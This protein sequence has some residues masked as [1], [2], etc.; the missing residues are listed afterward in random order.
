MVSEKSSQGSKRSK[1]LR[2][3]KDQVALAFSDNFANDLVK[4]SFRTAGDAREAETTA[5][6]QLADD[7]SKTDDFFNE[8][9]TE[10]HSTVA[11]DDDS[12]VGRL[13][14]RGSTLEDHLE[15]L[16]DDASLTSKGR[17]RQELARRASFLNFGDFFRSQKLDFMMGVVIVLNA[18]FLAWEY[19]FSETEID[20]NYE[21]W[22][23]GEV[24][25]LGI[26]LW[27]FAM[28]L[29]FRGWTEMTD[30]EE[31]ATEAQDTY[32]DLALNI[33]GILESFVIPY[34]TGTFSMTEKISNGDEGLAR[35]I[36]NVVKCFRVWRIF[37]VL[38]LFEE[39]RLFFDLVYRG[40]GAL[41]LPGIFQLVLLFPWALFAVRLIGRDGFG[42]FESQAEPTDSDEYEIYWKVQRIG[43]LYETFSGSYFA[44]FFTSEATEHAY[45]DLVTGSG[46]DYFT[47][48]IFFSLFL[49]FGRYTLSIWL[50][51]A[52]VE[53]AFKICQDWR[54]A[55]AWRILTKEVNEIKRA[56]G[57][58]LKFSR[59]EFVRGS[60]KCG[61]FLRILIDMGFERSL[62]VDPIYEYLLKNGVVDDEPA[63][64]I[65]DLLPVFMRMREVT[66]N[67][68]FIAQL[69]AAGTIPERMYLV[70]SHFG[71]KLDYEKF[72]SDTEARGNGYLTDKEARKTLKQQLEIAEG[73][74]EHLRT[75][76]EDEA[77]WLQEF[78]ESTRFNMFVVTV[79]TYQAVMIFY[80]YSMQEEAIDRDTKELIMYTDL[81]IL[82]IFVAEL[83]SR[84]I[85]FGLRNSVD[86]YGLDWAIV[87]AGVI[88][89]LLLPII[90]GTFLVVPEDGGSKS[91][92]WIS[93]LMKLFRV[94]RVVR[95]ARIFTMFKSLVIFER[96]SSVYKRVSYL[97]FWPLAFVLTLIFI[98]TLMTVVLIGRDDTMRPVVPVNNG[99]RSYELE[100]EAYEDHLMAYE[101]FSTFSS[102]FMAFSRMIFYEKKEMWQM[103][104]HVRWTAL[105][106]LV[107]HYMIVMVTF[108]CLI[109]W[110]LDKVIAETSK[111]RV[112]AQANEMSEELLELIGLFELNHS[113]SVKKGARVVDKDTF[114]SQFAKSRTFTFFGDNLGL[115][116]ED[117]SETFDICDSILGNKDG[118]LQLP[119]VLRM[120]TI[121]REMSE[122]S[123]VVA[124]MTTS[125]D[126]ADRLKMLTYWV[127]WQQREDA[128]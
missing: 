34:A 2:R 83:A 93:E 74:P 11:S 100:V 106:F 12:I 21:F 116:E 66:K 25:F 124:C 42:S 98:Y 47:A 53:V 119:E 126:Q 71:V 55:K 69:K 40:A 46:E 94:M 54:H 13:K 85:A 26:Y 63:D 64:F 115:E 104:F 57:G 103:M 75:L 61:P 16:P 30:N 49:V 44:N 114:V 20:K 8:S 36:M 19:S 122:N 109:A 123:K 79:I 38:K 67:P 101:N 86:R 81:G 51:V 118:S 24:L 5:L 68:K 52:V 92:G 107:F 87:V 62:I 125:G 18:C 91:G 31:S 27:E 105:W 65:N 41:V 10:E 127:E 58:R 121:F 82:T 59:K 78:V 48:T 84:V 76:D 102:A 35:S 80:E 28:R 108:S 112:Q 111:P 1:N 60:I 73:V 9:Q 77:T 45:W 110:I 14:K 17:Q 37:S 97:I 32:L 95:L 7:T 22:K 50:K 117:L 15:A 90:Q 3:E 89:D 33:L 29:L 120:W 113:L 39:F 96:L 88:G 43:A 128:K 99:Q 72:E 70:S 23:A 4:D 6:E 56:F